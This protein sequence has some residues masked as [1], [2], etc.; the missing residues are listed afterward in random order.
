MM[1]LASQ[2]RPHHPTQGACFASL[3]PTQAPRLP[4]APATAGCVSFHMHRH[5]VCKVSFHPVSHAV[6]H[7]QTEI[8]VTK[9]L[10]LGDLLGARPQET[11]PLC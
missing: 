8:Q 10:P 3:S 2:V 5:S 6:T 9:L 1:G 4:C 7:S 11:V